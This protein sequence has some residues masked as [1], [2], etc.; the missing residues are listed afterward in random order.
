MT[1][2]LMYKALRLS[3]QRTIR[4]QALLFPPTCLLGCLSFKERNC[5]FYLFKYPGTP[6]SYY[7]LLVFTYFV[8]SQYVPLGM[9]Q[10]LFVYKLVG[11]Y[12]LVLTLIR[13]LYRVRRNPI[14]WQFWMKEF[15]CSSEVGE[16]V[17]GYALGVERGC[18]DKLMLLSFVII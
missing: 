6:Y 18:S 2:L 3:F 4:V 11:P 15:N 14:F 8:P 13:N 9:N 16:M 1:S 17:L 5:A 12:A 10:G 7:F